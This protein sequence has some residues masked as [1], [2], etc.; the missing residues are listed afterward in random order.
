MSVHAAFAAADVDAIMRLL[1]YRM[2]EMS[3]AFEM[4]VAH[5]RTGV[6]EDMEELIAAPGFA[7]VPAEPEAIQV[8]PCCEGRIFQLARAD[9]GPLVST[10][11]TETSAPTTMQVFAALIDGQWRVVR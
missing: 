10:L 9:G 2:A 11:E 4:D 1:D 6:R 8:N 5:H 7:L 3:L